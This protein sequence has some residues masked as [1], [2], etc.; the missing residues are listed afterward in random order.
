MSFRFGAFRS[1]AFL[2]KKI[3]VGDLRSVPCLFLPPCAYALSW[4]VMFQCGDRAFWWTCRRHALSELGMA[5]FAEEDHKQSMQI[6]IKVLPLSVDARGRRVLCEESLSLA[7][8]G[9]AIALSWG[10]CLL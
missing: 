4:S 9:L 7:L 5:D 6:H 8:A 2:S 10:Y 3:L 1:R